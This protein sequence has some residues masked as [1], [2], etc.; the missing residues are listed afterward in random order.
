VENSPVYSELLVPVV[1]SSHPLASATRLQARD[2]AGEPI[3]TLA[4]TQTYEFVR[5]AITRGDSAPPPLPLTVGDVEVA[6]GLVAVRGGVA[7][8][9]LGSVFRNIAAGEIVRLDIADLPPPEVRITSLRLFEAQPE[10]TIIENFIICLR[11]AGAVVMSL[12]AASGTRRR[13]RERT[14]VTRPGRGR[15]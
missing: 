10:S 14:V 15:D 3:I 11:E 1:A 6:R 2:L 5:R 7:F 8:L 12:S 13:S 9:P 4:E